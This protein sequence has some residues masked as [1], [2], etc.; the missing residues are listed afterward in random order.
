MPTSS[1]SFLKDFGQSKGDMDRISVAWSHVAQ[2]PAA[3]TVH[4]RADW[5]FFQVLLAMIPAVAGGYVLSDHY[6]RRRQLLGSREG[7]R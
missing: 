6:W 5:K 3:K 1:L 7:V 2:R 4:G